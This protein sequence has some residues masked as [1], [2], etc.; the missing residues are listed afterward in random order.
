MTFANPY[1]TS[2]P[3]TD[4]QDFFG[5]DTEFHLMYQMLLSKESVNVMGARRI[6]KS[7]LLRSPNIAWIKQWSW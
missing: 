7:S 4:P 6:G 2:R 5:R 3:I 1:Q